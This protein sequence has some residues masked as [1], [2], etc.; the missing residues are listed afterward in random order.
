MVK[1][2]DT[3]PSLSQEDKKKVIKYIDE[4]IDRKIGIVC[5]VCQNK[6]WTIADD[7]VIPP[8]YKENRAQLLGGAGYPQ[9]ML[10]CGK[11][12]HTI[13]INA[14]RAGL[15]PGVP[16]ETEEPPATKKSAKAEEKP[17]G[18]SNG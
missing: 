4:R 2:P 8:V 16:E 14:V 6:K 11:C 3:A 5:S 7:L 15:V 12:G 1:K 18:G 10:L 9:V 17:G 13:F